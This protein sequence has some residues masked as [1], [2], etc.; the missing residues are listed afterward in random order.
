MAN[1]IEHVPAES[2][3]E[4]VQGFVDGGATEVTARQQPDG[5]WI[6]TEVH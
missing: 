4:V 6:V 1:A 5:T 2:V 3:G